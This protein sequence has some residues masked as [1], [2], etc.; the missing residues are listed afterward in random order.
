MTAAYT[1]RNRFTKQATGSNTNVWGAILNAVFDLMDF[2]MDGMVTVSAG[3]TTTLSSAN[4]TTD[5]ARGRFLNCT[6]TATMT[7][8]IPSVEKLYLV[9]AATHDVVIGI[10]GGA[11]ATIKGGDSAWVVCDGTTTRKVQ[12]N[13]FG[14]AKLRNIADGTD[15][16]DAVTY[17]QLVAAVFAS[18]IG[19]FPGL[20]GN[21]RKSLQPTEDETSVYWTWASLKPMAV[22][23][24][25]Y[26]AV[27]GDRLSADTS[28]GAFT[29]TLPE[30]PEAGD[31][32]FICDGD[33][34]AAAQGFALNNLTV[35]RNGSTINGLTE[36]VTLDV[37]GIGVQFDCTAANE[38]RA[39]SGG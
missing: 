35:A 19:S 34:T 13:D 20:P 31:K 39:H 8:V 38:W 33:S 17:A 5:Q 14:G 26:T 30:D 37:K 2:A 3:G 4:G 24:A 21:K 18:S 16:Q 25:D 12:S 32:V 11:T 10:S 9:R 22:V 1:A 15:D 7:V 36:D 29:V 6:A 27:Q 23:S 28:A